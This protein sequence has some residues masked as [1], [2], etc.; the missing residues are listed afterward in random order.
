[1]S[2]TSH[3]ITCNHY[4]RQNIQAQSQADAQALLDRGIE[5]VQQWQSLL[6]EK[7][8]ASLADISAKYSTD[9][10]LEFNTDL[11]F[12][13][14][15]VRNAL[16]QA[17][18]D[19][20]ILETYIHLLMPQMEDGNNF[21]VTV[22]M[23]VLKTMQD[24]RETLEKKLDEL[25]SYYSKRADAIEKL[26]LKNIASSSTTTATETLCKTTG[27][28]DG[29][30]GEEESKTSN[31]CV[32]ET[33]TTFLP[34]LPHHRVKHVHAIDVQQYA[35]LQSSLKYCISSYIIVLDNVMKNKSKLEMPK[36][37]SGGSNYSSM[38]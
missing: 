4:T 27:G 15:Q 8:G 5:T 29:N 10:T 35:S 26:G 22:Q 13:L 32:N 18:G 2:H 33:K 37:S 36:G 38:F 1:L 25:V 20:Q 17:V 14:Q 24:V 7:F 21:G 9:E 16:H 31:T 23:T 19:V 11:S 6:A 12:S 3:H 34:T 30:D 28:K